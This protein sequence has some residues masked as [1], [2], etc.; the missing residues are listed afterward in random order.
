MNF[1]QLF[2]AGILLIALWIDIAAQQG[3]SMSEKISENKRYPGMPDNITITNY[4][5]FTGW[6]KFRDNSN[7]IILLRKF[8]RGGE[9]FCLAADPVTL[10]TKVISTDSIEMHQASFDQLNSRYSTTPYFKG[11]KQASMNSDTLQDA[12]ITKFRYAEKGINLTVD[13]CP[14]QRPLD[15]IVF[16]DLIN[17]IGGVERPVPIAVSVTGRWILRHPRDLNWL[18]SLDKSGELDIIW[19]NHSYNHVTK[20]DVPLK[21][22]FMLSPGTDIN[23]EVLNTEI[24][25]LQKN[26][27]PSLF[28]RFPGL[29]SDHEIYV[30]ILKLG[31]IPVGSDA[32]LAKGQWPKDGSIVLIHANGNEPLGVREFI[33]LLNKKRPEALSHHWELLDLR[34]SLIDEETKDPKER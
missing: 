26:I 3:G 5:P 22:N 2:T 14:S 17:E 34:K 9:D 1:K 20:A 6:G 7:E 33:D 27:V 28:F 4:I 8:S 18:D 32:W 24:A 16:T 11:L 23:A 31:L 21:M 13:L 10:R 25:L 15:R 29:V 30:K 19:I 12:G